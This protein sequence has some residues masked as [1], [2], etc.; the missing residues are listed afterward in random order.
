MLP[1]YCVL[2]VRLRG[3]LTAAN[4]EVTLYDIHHPSPNRNR[5]ARGGLT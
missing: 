1:V 4:V 5:N 3:A 2:Y